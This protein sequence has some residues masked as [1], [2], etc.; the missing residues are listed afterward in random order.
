M[1]YP[2]FTIFIPCLPLNFWVVLAIAL[3]G[4]GYGDMYSRSPFYYQFI[5]TVHV[6]IIM[7]MGTWSDHPGGRENSATTRVVWDA[8][9]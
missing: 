1:G 3:C 6:K 7:L 9:G 2:S 5:I 4:S 8:L